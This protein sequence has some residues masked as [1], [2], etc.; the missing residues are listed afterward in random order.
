MKNSLFITKFALLILVFCQAAIGFAQTTEVNIENRIAKVGEDFCTKIYL[1]NIEEQHNC[2][3]DLVW[4]KSI[5]KFNK[6]KSLKKNKNSFFQ[7]TNDK[8]LN[9]TFNDD[10]LTKKINSFIEQEVCF[11]AKK[12]ANTKFSIRNDRSAKAGKS[13]KIRLEGGETIINS[14][15]QAGVIISA[16]DEEGS[17]GSEVCV[18]IIVED[19]TNIT[20]LSF[21]LSWNLNVIDFNRVD[22][23][24]LPGLDM[25]T[26]SATTINLQFDWTAPNVNTGVTV[27]NGTTIFSVCF[28]VVG[29]SGQSSQIAFITIPTTIRA[30]DINSNGGDIGVMNTFGSV[31]VPNVAPMEFDNFNVEPENCFGPLNGGVDITVIGGIPPYTFSWSNMTTMEDLSGA[32]AGMYTVTVMDS[33]NPPSSIDRSFTIPADLDKPDADAGPT[34]QI[35]CIDTQLTLDGTASAVGP[36]IE[37]EWVATN[38]GNI[39]SGADTNEPLVDAAGTYTIR[40]IDGSNGCEE[41][42][43]V[44]VTQNIVLPTVD[45]GEDAS[46]PCSDAGLNLMGVN[47][48]ALPNISTTWTTLNGVIESG[49]STLSPN[50]SSAGVYTLTIVNVDNGCE[51]FDEVTVTE[52]VPPNAIILEAEDLNC[53]RTEVT[54]DG[55]TSSSGMSISYAWSTTNGGFVSGQNTPM[56]VVNLAGTYTLTVVDFLTECTAEATVA[57]VGNTARPDAD[58]GEDITLTCADPSVTIVGRTTTDNVSVQWQDMTGTVV[59]DSE[60]ITLSIGGTYTFIVTN[61][62]GCSQTDEVVIDV[63]MEDP[64]ADA[65]EGFE[66]G[67]AGTTLT[68]DGSGS[69]QGPEFEYT[70]TTANGTLESGFNTLMPEVSS[71]GI[72]ELVVTNTNNGCDAL[73]TVEITLNGNLPPA[74]AGED[75]SLC[76]DNTVLMGNMTNGITGQ[77]SSNSSADIDNVSINN[78][79]VTSLQTGAN[80]FTW[81]LSTADC[82]DYS[83]DDVNI[84]VEGAPAANN[85]QETI[86]LDSS[87]VGFDVLLN[88]NLNSSSGVTINFDTNDPNFMDLGNGVFTYT[89]P[90][91]SINSF[92]FMYFVCNEICPTLCDSATVNINREAAPIEPIDPTKLPNTFTPNGD[93][94]ND[95]FIFDALLAEPDKYPEPEFTV[96]NRWGDV[97]FTSKPYRNDWR[98]T[99]EQGKDLPDGTYYYVLRLSIAE[100]DLYKGDVTILR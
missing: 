80:I 13:E 15:G 62:F 66:I 20:E 37:Y 8:F 61:E 11:E 57:V 16:S 2:S 68:L 24:N 50:V 100:G 76:D 97:V 74:D 3:F 70:W 17:P 82:P 63:D 5:L 42:A 71:A 81:T 32:A 93:N 55:S 9:F 33:N 95:A 67:C 19:F 56:P 28:D 83:S 58:A 84:F 1:Y 69:S 79:N 4:D 30:S 85:D 41:T 36:M 27:P 35:D 23:I 89:F 65:G 77:W 22:N 18:D 60:M 96:F 38:G 7:F 6:L 47:V 51:A 21:T 34:M 91:D 46:L 73:S 92:T 72:Y 52:A 75:V 39:V 53:D 59:S 64:I 29:S 12:I 54:L 40:V 44:E 45:A 26:Y 99:N 43:S 48:D 94:V 88:D 49:A 90:S 25:T 98:G 86:F 10:L 78:P 87:N 31:T 14:A